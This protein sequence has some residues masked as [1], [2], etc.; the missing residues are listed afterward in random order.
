MQGACQYQQARFAGSGLGAQ[1]DPVCLEFSHGDDVL[2][3]CNR[4]REGSGS[5]PDVTFRKALLQIHVQ[6][7]A[8]QAAALQRSCRGDG[9]G[10]DCH[11]LDCALF[12]G[13]LGW[14]EMSRHPKLPLWV[15]VPPA[16]FEVD[17]L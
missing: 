12:A 10:F 5:G 13:G 3:A 16:F 8:A 15:K 7:I 2:R 1:N 9:I 4:C 11:G 17:A 14:P 6:Y